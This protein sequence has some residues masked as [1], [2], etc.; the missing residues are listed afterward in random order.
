[1]ALREHEISMLAKF[2][3][4]NTAEEVIDYM[5]TYKIHLSIKKERRRILGD[6]RPAHNGKPHRISINGNLNAYH[7]LITFL[8]ELAHLLTYLSHQGRVNPHGQEWKSVFKLLLKRFQ[9]KKV[10]PKDIERALDQ[11]MSNLAASTCSDP[12]L[13]KVLR[14][15]DHK[16]DV[17]LVEQIAMGKL[18][19]TEKGQIFKM[20]EKR[21]TRFLCE[22]ER[23]GKRYLF[24]SIYEVY[25][26]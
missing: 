6:Y 5:H 13:Y 24:P 18:F 11:S 12:D 8:H 23:T 14:Q 10:F 21:R 9:D 26:V 3:P 20:I 7:F 4:A 16:K 1:M 25:K 22:E 15:Y 2:L 17:F 19:K